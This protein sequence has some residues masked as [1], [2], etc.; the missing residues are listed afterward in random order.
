[1]LMELFCF[2]YLYDFYS[3]GFGFFPQH[4]QIDALMKGKSSVL[5]KDK[6]VFRATGNNHSEEII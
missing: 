4:L 6:C 5:R 2:L 3:V 1:M